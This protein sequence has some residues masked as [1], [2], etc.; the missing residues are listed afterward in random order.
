MEFKSINNQIEE[1]IKEHFPVQQNETSNILISIIQK[2]IEKEEKQ[3]IWENSPYKNLTKLQKN[4]VGIVGEK[5]LN[6][7]CYKHGIYADC[8]GAKTK[9][10]GGGQGDGQIMGHPIEIKTAYQGSYGQ[11][12]QHE[13]GEVPW[14]GSKYMI[15]IDIS[16]HW[17][18]M[19]IFKNF[20]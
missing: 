16:P 4:N 18:Y 8:N 6:D 7:I 13:L 12:F 9:Q 1:E 15:F 17:F 11:S 3:N 10:I 19:T 2:Q 14:K 5:L 20:D